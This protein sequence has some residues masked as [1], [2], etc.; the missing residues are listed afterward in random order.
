[1]SVGKTGGKTGG[2]TEVERR[3]VSIHVFLG[4]EIRRPRSGPGLNITQ[5]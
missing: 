5:I 3:V 4:I 2:K 1:M